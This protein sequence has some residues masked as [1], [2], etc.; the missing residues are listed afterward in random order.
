ML[1]ARKN[2][3]RHMRQLTAPWPQEV[4]VKLLSSKGGQVNLGIEL[5]GLFRL[6]VTEPALLAIVHDAKGNTNTRKI[7]VDA[8]IAIDAKANVPALG[9]L[10]GAADEAL[11]VRERIANALAGTNLPEARM[12]LLQALETAPARLQ[13]AI[14]GGLAGSAQ[15]A[16]QLL[17]AVAEGK[18]S[19]R[20]LQVP[21]ISFRLHQAKIANVGDRIATLTKGLPAADQRVQTLLNQR[22]AGFQRAHGDPTIGSKIFEKHCAIC[23]LI[24]NKGAKIG[25]QLDGVGIRGLERLLEDTLDPSRNVDQAF[26][27]TTLVFNNGQLVNGLMSAPRR[28]HPGARR[29]RRQGSPRPRKRRARAAHLPAVADARQHRRAD[30]RERFLPFA[31]V[32]VGA[33]DEAVSRQHQS[34]PRPLGSGHLVSLGHSLTVVARIGVPLRRISCFIIEIADD[35]GRMV[36]HDRCF[37]FI[38]GPHADRQIP[39]RPGRT[40]GTA[41]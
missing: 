12:A 23:H 33:A 19:G 25:P 24:A 17:K 30:S 13:E 3:A 31:G 6:P 32:S 16:E 27:T 5:A 9:N 4:T 40:F 34:E 35:S 10:L 39:R 2:A 21:A 8:L 29:H 1:Q 36:N 41:A 20:L 7:A 37:S 11:E 28:Q 22:R 15:G 38:R 14:A 26:R 18:A